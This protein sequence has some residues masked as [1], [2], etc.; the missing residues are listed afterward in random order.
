[1]PQRRRA[2]I[3]C[4]IHGKVLPALLYSPGGPQFPDA[5]IRRVRAFLESHALKS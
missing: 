5:S 2:E 3:D 1:M 4:E